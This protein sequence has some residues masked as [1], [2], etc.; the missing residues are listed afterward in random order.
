MKTVAL[1]IEVYKDYFLVMLKDEHKTMY[2]EM[3]EGHDL[4][5]DALR[6]VLGKVCVV[7]FN[8]NSYDMPLVNA[9]L[10]GAS[11]HELK[12]YSDDIIVNDKRS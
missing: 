9:A 3:Y 7:T 11:C 2:Y 12:D 4:N 1:D 5:R 8:G 6:S 10:E